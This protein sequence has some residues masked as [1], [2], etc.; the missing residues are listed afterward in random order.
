MFNV[1][2]AALTVSTIAAAPAPSSTYGKLPLSFEQNMGQAP[3]RVRFLSRGKGY[4]VFLAPAEAVVETAAE[5]VVRAT[6]VGGNRAAEMTALD[7]LPGRSNYFVGN[8]PQRW[9]T[10]IP[11]YERVKSSNVYPGID[12][13]YYGHNGQLEFDFVIAPHADANRIELAFSGITKLEVDRAGDLLLYTAAGRLQQKR[14]RIYQDVNGVKREIR[15]EYVLR[16]RDRVRFRV[17]TY[18]RDYSLIIDPVLVYSTYLGGSADDSGIGIAVDGAGNAYLVGDTLSTNFPTANAMQNSFAGGADSGDAFIAKLNPSGTALVYSTYL[19]GNGSDDAVS[20]AI[21]SAGNAYLTGQTNSTNFPTLNPLQATFGGGIRDAWVAKLNSTGSALV[22]STYIGGNDYDFGHSISVDSAGY[23]YLA[24]GTYSLNFP[25]ANAIQPAF[26]GNFN[27]AIALKLNPT[28]TALVYSTYLGGNGQ[29]IAYGGAIDIAGNFYLC[30]ITESTNFP[31]ANAFQPNLIGHRNGF[32][33]KLNSTG[34]ALSYSTYLGGSVGD[35]AVDIAVDPAGNAYV[36]G[37]AASNDFPIVNAMQPAF[38]GFEDSF[39]TKFTTTGAIVYS[40][41]LGG[42]GDDFG[43]SV[44]IDAA[45]NAYLTGYTASTNF[46]LANAIQTTQH[47]N[48]DAYVAELDPIGSIL[49]FSTY[50]G[51]SASDTGEHIAVDGAGSLYVIGQTASTNFPTANPLQQKVGGSFDAFV[52]KLGEG[53]APPPPRFNG[54]GQRTDVNEFLTYA[55][56]TQ[57]DTTLAAGTSSFDVHIFYGSTILPATFQAT[58][59]GN[60]ISGFTPIP[61][62]D[63]TVTIPLA[64]GRNTL[65]L[66]V[67]GV[68][69]D[70][71][72]GTDRDRLVFIVP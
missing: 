24:G 25:T 68:R 12:L 9:R 62:T 10:N 54:G 61:G 55:A 35:Y 38:G 16:S 15:G 21:D 59:N 36:T 57:T 13:I 22:Y 26:G 64:S 34:S 69:T 51:G 6:V 65:V 50:L 5:Q 18:D 11:T 8:D 52:A 40:T 43:T 4:E 45:G 42:S 39:V 30:G 31:T 67:D 66:R 14:P 48:T 71:H 1:L 29:D 3:G 17:G 23:V 63:Q 28:G 70:G 19:G 32:V 53:V 20:V 7:P 60:P 33:A 2:M 46:P 58:L 56:P 49:L 44:A 27:D 41:Y 47:G 72:I 37:S